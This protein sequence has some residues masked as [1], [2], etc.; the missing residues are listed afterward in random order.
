MTDAEAHAFE[1][2]PLFD[3]IIKMRSWDEKAKIKGLDVPGLDEYSPMIETIVGTNLEIKKATARAIAAQCKEDG[4][5]KA[6]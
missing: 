3:T 5:S 2:S 1:R 6:E 4:E